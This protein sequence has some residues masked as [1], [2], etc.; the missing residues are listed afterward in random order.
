MPPLSS[1]RRTCLALAIS[2]TLTLP[3]N[4][5]TI[6]VNDNGDNGVNND[7]VC[8]LREAVVTV[9]TGTDTGNQTNAAGCFVNG[10]LGPTDTITFNNTL[11]GSTITLTQAS[12]LVIDNA[13]VDLTIEGLGQDSLTIDGGG[14]SRVFYIDSATVSIN[15]LTI[16]G[17][18]TSGDGGGINARNSSRV[19]LANSTVSNN[20]ATI[21]GGG[22]YTYNSSSM[23]L[24]NS[25]VSNNSSSLGG[26]ID[27][28]NS[29]MTLIN[30]TVSNNSASIYGGG[31]HVSSSHVSLANST[32]SNNSASKHGGGIYAY[33][34][35]SVSLTNSVLSNNSATSSGTSSGGGTFAYSS[36][37][38]LVS[39]IVSNNSASRG[40]G[41]FAHDSSNVSFANSTVSNNS[42][43]FGGG[44]IYTDISSSVNLTN[45][46]V[47]NNS[48]SI[49][50]GGIFAYNSSSVSLTNSITSGNTAGTG[51]EIYSSGI[52]ST[53]TPAHNNLFGHSSLTLAQAFTN[54][55]P[56]ATDINATNGGDNIALSSILNTTLA[57]NGCQQKA[58]APSTAACVQTHVLVAG[59]PAIDGADEAVCLGTDQRGKP[60]KDGMMMP[61]KTTTGNI[62]VVNLGDDYCDIGSVEFSSG[63]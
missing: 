2:Q 53:L 48:A 6:E 34:S 32:V 23:S 52:G 60:R 12:D 31:I 7:N 47:S 13:S 45:S 39:S 44:G 11:S 26:G 10:T 18:S 43:S 61:I 17:G 4:A 24:A 42:A 40:G 56:G 59:S 29:S 41:I 46:T 14:N 3:I 25:T 21:L 5:A 51:A 38:S 27:V 36:S 57:N 19:S 20:S 54:F 50:G 62:A 58:G 22:I 9:N 1:F 16:S 63:D 49:K 30:S 33:D 35:S 55:T 37:V 8:T 15:S 28:F